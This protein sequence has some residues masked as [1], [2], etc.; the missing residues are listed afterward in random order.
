MAL[1]AEFGKIML[2]LITSRYEDRH[3]RRESRRRLVAAERRR[4]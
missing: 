4:R 1:D 2:Q 3:W